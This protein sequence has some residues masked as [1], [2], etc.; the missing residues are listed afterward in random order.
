MS[1][2]LDCSSH[3]EKVRKIED[4]GVLN[5]SASGLKLLPELLKE[6]GASWT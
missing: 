1:L 2:I 4:L 6:D 3:A 5:I